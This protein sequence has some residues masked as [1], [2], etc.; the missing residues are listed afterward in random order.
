MPRTLRVAPDNTVH[1]V[2]NRRNR[3]DTLFQSDADYRHF[4]NLMADGIDRVPMRVLAFCLMPTHWHIVLWPQHGVELSAYI[5]WLSNAHVRQ[6]HQRHGTT[7]LGHV[8]Q[9]RFKNFIVQSDAHMFRVLRYVEANPL[10]AGLV[11]SAEEWRWS[12]LRDARAPNGGQ[13]VCDWPLPRPADWLDYVNRGIPA[14]ELATLQHAAR[15]G[16]PY[17]D[18]RWVADTATRYGLKSTLAIHGR[19][20]KRQAAAFSVFE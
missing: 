5:G 7:G 10:R 19:P 8:Y 1:H 11:S 18:K 17:G 9:G 2:L 14:D 12:S 4:L 3:K 15:R 13:I 6:H 20:A 16:A